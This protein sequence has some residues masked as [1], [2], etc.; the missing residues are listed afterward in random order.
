MK[1]VTYSATNAS[2]IELVLGE[3]LSA[4]GGENTVR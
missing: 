4:E 3:T 2:L 1:D